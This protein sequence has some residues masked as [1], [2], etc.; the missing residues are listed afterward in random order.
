MPLVGSV[1]YIN[2]K[3]FL[4]INTVGISLDMMDIYREVRAL[5][6]TNE[7]DRKFDPMIIA[8]GNVPKT[9]TTFT[10]PYVQ[11]LFGCE[12]IPW[13]ATQVLTSIRDTFTD[14]GRVDGEVFNTT[15][16]VNVV[17]IVI[18]VEKVEVREIATGGGGAT[19]DKVYVDTSALVNGDGTAGSPFDN[20]GDAIDF[21]EANSIK[22]IVA[23]AEITLDR[24]LKNFTVLG[25]GVPVINT[26]GFDLKGSKFFQCTMRG[27][28]LDRIIV[29]E[30]V[31]DN[32]FELNGF[33]EKCA[34]NGDVICIDGGSVLLANCFS[35]MTG[36]A[37]PS[38]SL[39]G[40]GSSTASVSG[41]KGSLTVKDVNNA[42]DEVNLGMAEGELILENTCTA[43]IIKPSGTVYFVDNSNG[44]TVDT[45]ALVTLDIYEARDWS[46]QSAS[47]RLSPPA[48]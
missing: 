46:K 1:D 48:P 16:F 47:Q 12:I 21:A 37:Q 13:D 20:I 2:K 15:G 34:L 39:N 30:S 33:F 23:Y 43:G 40:I 5:R 41:Y 9:I 17:T 7:A 3:I 31:L 28:Y 45:D 36:V 44:S 18:D 19:A 22:Q 26:A 42:N 38:L 24:N 27:T 25:I 29:Q 35:L 4:S 32:N 14:D 8:D 10:Q 6:R 11:L